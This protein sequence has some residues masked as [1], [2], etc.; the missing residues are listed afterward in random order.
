MNSSVVVG[1]VEK[2]LGSRCRNSSRQSRRAARKPD[3]RSG[4]RRPARK[5]AIAFRRELPRRRNLV[6]CD[7]RDLAPTTRS[8]ASRCETSR[9]ASAERRCPSPSTI[10]TKV[11]VAWRMPV[12]TA[13]PLPLLYGCRMTRAP[14]S[15]ARCAVSSVDPSSTTSI[16]RQPA[17]ALSSAIS[18]P[19]AGPSSRAGMTTDVASGNWV[20]GELENCTGNCTGTEWARNLGGEAEVD[21]VAVLH[22]VLLAL[23]P[24]FAVIAADGHRAPADQRVVADDLSTDESPRDVGVDFAGREMRCGAPRDRPGAAL[25]L[26]DGEERNI[27][28]QVVAGADDAI[29]AG[30]GQTEIL[31]KRGGVGAV[32]LGNLELDLRTD[33][34][35]RRSRPRQE[36]GDARRFRCSSD[37]G[38]RLAP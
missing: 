2:P 11:P 21:D 1:G 7:E 38:R 28:E 34:D 31:E 6:A 16:S 32:E 3:V 25:I 30:L 20:I 27:A 4:I 36:R 24:D 17:A 13:A 35:G 12:L 37:V 29:E 18:G 26:P 8:C 9:T 10:S 5:P 33:R 14:A 15:A 22:D 23:E 19:M